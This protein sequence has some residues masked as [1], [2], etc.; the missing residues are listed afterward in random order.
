MEEKKHIVYTA[1]DLQ[2]YHSGSMNDNEMNALEKAALDD[3]FLSDALEGYAFTEAAEKD[4]SELK[5][6]LEQK[7]EKKKVF[8]LLSSKSRAWISAAAVLVL[9]L[10]TIYFTLKLN[11]K[12]QEV[13]LAKI[14]DRKEDSILV[15]RGSASIIQNEP[16]S[17][18]APIAAD[19]T[20]AKLNIQYA[21]IPTGSA[22]QKTEAN[23]YTRT[24]PANKNT[25]QKTPD[26]YKANAEGVLDSLPIKSEAKKN[27]RRDAAVDEA[28]LKDRTPLEYEN[29]RSDNY[30]FSGKVIDQQG[31]PV[32]FASI[33][34]SLKKSVF[35]TDAS[36]NFSISAND[37]SLFATIAAVGYDKLKTNLKSNIGQTIVLSR[38]TQELSAVVVTSLGAVRQKASLGYSTATVK[39][40]ELQG[41]VAGIS[42]VSGS[43]PVIGKLKYN[44]V[45]IDSLK[46][47]AAINDKLNKG[48][49]VLS[50]KIKKN[51]EPKNIRVEKKL[52]QACDEEA[53]RLLRTGPKWKYIND[54]RT[55]VTI[56]F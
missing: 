21:N 36:G 2:R 27:M 4:I 25:D 53:I 50:F 11:T 18:P 47:S 29:L 9:I 7:E 34:D 16:A 33:N 17:K 31:N 14:E 55:I 12:K 5:K 41:K 24:V 32:A 15:K 26:F 42:V 45:L 48:S 49:V 10:G 38:N 13:V 37:S 46:N 43:E 3:P 20:R 44:Q 30:L 35:T 1:A 54:K 23:T 6:R 40:S 52:C 19:T 39:A 28:V 56:N 8:V 22:I 51:G